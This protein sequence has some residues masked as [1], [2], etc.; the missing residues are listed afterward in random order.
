MRFV[1][2]RGELFFFWY[3]GKVD[4]SDFLMCGEID[5]GEAIQTGKLSKDAF[6]RAVRIAFERHRADPEVEIH[7]P[8]GLLG[9]CIDR[10][11]CLSRDRPRNDVLPVGRDI[12]VVDGAFDRDALDFLY[13]YRVDDVDSAWRNRDRDVN[14]AAVLAD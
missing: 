4:A 10:G 7:R 11:N 14:M 2:P 8:Y 6:G 12:R 1:A 3:L 5:D 13:R 9:L